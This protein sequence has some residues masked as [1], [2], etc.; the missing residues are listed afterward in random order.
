MSLLFSLLT[1]K[2]YFRA[3]FGKLTYTVKAREDALSYL[4]EVDDISR[5]LSEE[6]GVEY[7]GLPISKDPK[8][9]GFHYAA[10]RKFYDGK[11]DQFLEAFVME[12]I[13]NRY[14]VARGKFKADW[15]Q[16][17][18]DFVKHCEVSSE[19]FNNGFRLGNQNK[20]VEYNDYKKLYEKYLDIPKLEREKF[21][22]ELI[23]KKKKRK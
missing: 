7:E 20:K 3:S 9:T 5:E 18:E 2:N 15:K 13:L 11:P 16:V 17:Y 14:H 10:F 1:W 6:N 22:D 12:I 21:I 4:Q 19:K 23:K 8:I